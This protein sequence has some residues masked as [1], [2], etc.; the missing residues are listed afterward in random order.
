MF[1][2]RAFSGGIQRVR[3]SALFWYSRNCALKFLNQFRRNAL[4][5]QFKKRKNLSKRCT[6]SILLKFFNAAACFPPVRLIY[7]H[8]LLITKVWTLIFY[9]TENNL[10]NFCL[11]IREKK[12]NR[13]VF[14]HVRIFYLKE[15]PTTPWRH[16]W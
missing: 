5:N 16:E 8:S 12:R 6:N 4:K 7:S 10:S 13:F 15:K 3:T 9:R 14:N 1:L 2:R 11:I